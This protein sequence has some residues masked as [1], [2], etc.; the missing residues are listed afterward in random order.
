VTADALVSDDQ[1]VVKLN[2]NSSDARATRAKI[3]YVFGQQEKALADFKGI[4]ESGKVSANIYNDFAWYLA[5]ARDSSRRDAV[6]ALKLAKRANELAP[7][8]SGVLNKKNSAN[9]VQTGTAANTSSLSPDLARSL[10]DWFT[11]LDQ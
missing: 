7:T 4:V 3:L 1:E 8:G 10:D 9:A 5:T 6:E 11:S 2:G